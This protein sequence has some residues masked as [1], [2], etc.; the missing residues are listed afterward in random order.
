MAKHNV[1]QHATVTGSAYYNPVTQPNPWDRMQAEGYTYNGA[2]ENIAAGYADAE[3]AYVGWWNSTGH[4]ANMF[5]NAFREIGDGYFFW[6]SSTYQRYFTMDLGCSGNHCFFTDTIFADTNHNSLYD[7]GEGVAGIMVTL[8]VGGVLSSN[9]DL[10]SAVGSFAIPIQTISSGAAVQVVISN[11]TPASLHLTIP[12]DYRN[13]SAVTLTPGEMQV[14]GSF[15]QAASRG[16]FGFRDLTTGQAL[17][18]APLM[19]A[20]SP[21]GIS[22]VWP[23]ELG[24]EYQPQWT[25]DFIVWTDLTSVSQVGTGL[26]IAIVDTAAHTMGP[27]FYRLL[28]RSP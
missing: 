24:L 23:T 12:R 7:Q 21:A 25:T 11:T 2:G 1:F 3:A 13:Y 18:P 8:V 20:A 22:L 15:T 28:I 16:N 26:P 9:Y 6:S 17:V 27:R 4:R 10:S 14:V 5:N 19:I